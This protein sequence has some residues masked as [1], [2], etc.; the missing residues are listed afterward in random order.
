MSQSLRRRRHGTPQAVVVTPSAASTIVDSTI[1]NPTN[2]QT[3]AA[4]GL[5]TDDQVEIAGHTGSTPAIDGV[6][7][8]TVVDPT[9]FTI[10][11]NVTVAGID[12]TAVSP[13]LIDPDT[14]QMVAAV[15]NIY[16]VAPTVG[17]EAGTW[18]SDTPADATIDQAG[19]VTT[20]QAGT[21]AINFTTTRGGIG[22]A[23]ISDSTPAA[24]TVE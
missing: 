10:P 11:I 4:H 14:L 24:L 15:T 16:G 5:T 21:S 17:A 2:I 9:N 13:G 12:G 1:A 18:S 20:V 19:L 22:Q 8:V 7:V 3:V 23:G 6:R